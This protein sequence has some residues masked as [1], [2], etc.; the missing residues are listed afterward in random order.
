MRLEGI[1]RL[2]H[3]RHAIREEQDAFR[4][5]AAHQQIAQRDHCPRLSGARRHHHQR[6][7][8][9]ILFKCLADPPDGSLL[10]V[11]LDDLPI[12][13]RIG[14][15]LAALPPLDHQL[16]FL[17]FVKAL[18]LAWRGIHIVPHPVLVAVA[19][20]NDRAPAK[21]LFQT[22]RVELRLLL[23]ICGLLLVR[24]ASFSPSGL[25]SSPQS[26]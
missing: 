1:H 8:V 11:A 9:S 2:I 23:P 24:F 18:H 19:V 12:D 16:Q 4:P 17:L 5:V 26:M 10:I 14:Q 13:F 7:A 15:L 3:Q 20:K 22:V 6:L 21:L 25:P